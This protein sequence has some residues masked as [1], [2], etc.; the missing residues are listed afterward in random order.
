M[1]KEFNSKLSDIRPVSLEE[2]MKRSYLDYAMSVIV[3]RALPDIRDGLK[4]VHR[5]I[6]YAMYEAGN[7]NDKPHRK[8]SNII[9]YT[10]M[11]FHP[12]GD[13][14]IYDALVRMSQDFSLRCPLIDGQG[15][16]GSL[17]GDPPA[18]ARY[19]EARLSKL[20][21]ELLFD[22]D[23]E[24]VEFQ[25]NYDN[26]ANEP[27]VLPS[28]FPNILINGAN[29]IAVG[30]AT[31]IPTHN[32]GEVIDACC[33]ILKNTDISIE[34][35][36]KYIPGPD[37]PTG[38]VIIGEK[39]IRDAYKSG[40]G[41]IIIRSKTHL[42]KIKGERLSI[43]IDEI[44]FQVNKSKLVE[45]IAETVKEKTIEGI[46][47]IRDESNRDGLRIV[48]ELKK[49][50]SEEVILNKLFYYTPMQISFSINMLV[51]NKGKPEQLPLKSILKNFIEFRE[52]I[53][54]KRIQYKLRKL[55]EEAHT[56]SGLILAINNLNPIITSI[57]SS[58]ST[59]EAKSK[60]MNIKWSVNEIAL[61]FLNGLDNEIS[62]KKV[63]DNYILS[64][65]Q[66]QSILDLRLQRLTNLEQ[67]KMMNDLKLIVY[68]IK[69]LDAQLTSKSKITDLM[70]YEFQNIK[71]NFSTPR[72]TIIDQ[73][74]FLPFKQEEDLIQKEDMVVTIS[75]EGY[76]KRVP[77]S[78]YKAQRRGGKGRSGM[79]TKDEDIVSDIFIT[80]TCSSLLFFTNKGRVY[81]LKSYKVPLCTPNSRGRSIKNLFPLNQ[82]EIV[83]AVIV[84]PEEELKWKS[85]DIL[86]ATSFGNVRRNKLSD[87]INIKSN[88]K[89]A[90]RLK[91]SE[92]L[93]GAEIYEDLSLKNR[94]IIL[95]TYKGKIIRFLIDEIRV[96]SGR[97]SRGV[98][99]IKLGNNDKVIKMAIVEHV[100]IEI[101]KRDL[102]L[103][104]KYGNNDLYYK[105]NDS[106]ENSLRES[107]DQISYFY[108]L[109]SM[110][111]Y[112]LT[113]TEK[114]YG[115]KSSSYEYRC[116]SRGG[117]GLDNIL[118]N[119]KNGGVVTT[120]PINKNDQVVLVS[121]TGQLIRCR[122]NEIRL[123]K[124]RTQGVKI[125]N[126]S[127]GEWVSAVSIIRNEEE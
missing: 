14:P 93:I 15:N 100:D 38:A 20:A 4:P 99:G 106:D 107:N 66:V 119:K 23:Y 28:K 29:G 37:F 27:R 30:M 115:K 114:G 92:I 53:L 84:L 127:E 26:S 2:E 73:D 102:F 90:M 105:K 110:E 12:H 64:E 123:T 3:S 40:R 54:I 59:S 98:R 22:I 97:N 80:S 76:I 35:L 68:K 81:Q 8:S 43:V 117:S 72:K 57:R 85:M 74:T 89:I 13:I 42:E 108:N 96:F 55:R 48:I 7:S 52:E 58:S 71:E 116:I 44:P 34:E 36:F 67:D 113:I 103:K 5:R 63:E 112:F 6:L 49:D 86:F 125:F 1:I 56:I 46:G 88:G 121:N 83:T 62:I 45:R 21:H 47:D 25:S 124:R 65:A 11:R 77:L 109:D 78:T 101:E 50:V 95:S 16:F 18:A 79:L 120:L 82:N 17:D 61:S 24:T 118:I 69:E 33:A 19:T 32:L 39:S 94:D 126:L 10:M 104:W 122:V 70:Y 111:Q 91:D 41:S 9:G 31:S 87:F 60:I 75:L 51:L